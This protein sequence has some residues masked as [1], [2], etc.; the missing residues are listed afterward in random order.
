MRSEARGMTEAEVLA[1][2]ADKAGRHH[3]IRSLE[4]D[5]TRSSKGRGLKIRRRHVP[6]V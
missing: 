3:P 1:T 6:W 5:E 4:S 2:K